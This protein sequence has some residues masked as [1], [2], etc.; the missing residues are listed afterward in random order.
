MRRAAGA[1]HDRAVEPAIPLRRAGV[2]IVQE[3]FDVGIGRMQKAA[4]DPQRVGGADRFGAL[5]RQRIGQRLLL[6]RHRDIG[7]DIIARVQRLHEGFEFVRRHRLAAV[8]AGDAVSFQPVVMNERR[9][10][11]FDRP[12]DDASGADGRGHA[13]STTVLR[14]MPICGHST[15]MVSP[16]FSHT[17]GSTFGPCFTGVPVQITSPA[18]SVMNVVVEAMMSANEK[19][20][21]AVV[22]SWVASPFSRTVR[23]SGLETST[24]VSIH[25]PMPPVA[26]KFL[27]WVTLN[28]PCRVQSR[29]VPSLA[30]VMPAISDS[31]FSFGTCLQSRPITMAISP[32]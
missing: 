15:S 9:A 25:G 4:G 10:R 3:T 11:M 7:A 12:A 8:F 18:L 16:G 1:D 2:E 24:S 26:S 30:S 14:R 29:M 13:S 32:S 22:S 27:P 28:W 21:L 23:C 20:M 31:A 19:I 17:G 6:V 5:V